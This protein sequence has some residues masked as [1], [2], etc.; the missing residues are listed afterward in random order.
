[1]KKILSVLLVAAMLVSLVAAIGI[2]AAAID[3]EWIVYSKAD[4]YMD[5][6]DGDMMSI[7]GYEYTEEGLK[8]IPADWKDF[9][10]GAGVQTKEKVDIKNGVYMEVRVDE[11]SNEKDFWFNFNIWSKPM[12]KAGKTDVEKWGYGVQELI[13]SNAQYSSWRCEWSTGGFVSK[14]STNISA[15]N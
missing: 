8:V 2:P 3:G 6:F 14:G 1:M 5:D 12:F 15:D 13:R 10:P 4:H 11:F 9:T 7:P